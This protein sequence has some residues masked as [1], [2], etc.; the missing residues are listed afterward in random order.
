MPLAI[1]FPNVAKVYCICIG[2]VGY[3]QES[4]TFC[5]LGMAT[6]AR[7]VAGAPGKVTLSK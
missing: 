5:M 3:A 1:V 7:N 2:N 4:M 6:C